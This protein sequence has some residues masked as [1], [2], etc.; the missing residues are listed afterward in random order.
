MIDIIIIKSFTYSF[1]KLRIDMILRLAINIFES[2]SSQSSRQ[3]FRGL[4]NYIII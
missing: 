3:A 1:E 2:F 4:Y